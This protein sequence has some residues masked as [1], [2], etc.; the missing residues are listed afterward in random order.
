MKTLIISGTY[1]TKQIKQ[2]LDSF[3]NSYNTIT[4]FNINLF[5]QTKE[6]PV[7]QYITTKEVIVNSYA[8]LV[9][10][11]KDIYCNY[12]QT[13]DFNIITIDSLFEIK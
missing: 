3:S 5:G 8:Q 6:N 2:N 1:K 9:D 10:K 7:C 12:F 13:D 4:T 11:C